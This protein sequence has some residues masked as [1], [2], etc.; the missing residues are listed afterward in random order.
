[1]STT[2]ESNL[3]DWICEGAGLVGMAAA[4]VACS[5]AY[6]G[7]SPLG[8][9]IAVALSLGGNLLYVT[10]VFARRATGNSALTWREL[11][12]ATLVPIVALLVTIVIAGEIGGLFHLP[13]AGADSAPG[14]Q[15]ITLDKNADGKV[16]TH[17]THAKPSD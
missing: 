11:V 5:L 10:H 12:L 4:L 8:F 15:V 3:F 7:S 2:R 14:K 1:M 17:T 16:V 13:F 6:S 9:W